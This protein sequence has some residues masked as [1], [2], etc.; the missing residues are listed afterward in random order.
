MEWDF[1]RSFPVVMK[2]FEKSAE[3]KL[4]QRWAFN[5]DRECSF[6]EFKNSLSAAS[7]KYKGIERSANEILEDVK[8][9]LDSVSKEE[10]K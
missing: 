4:F 1:I 3:E 10:A 5:Y 8:S 9:I 6:E 7:K 2:A